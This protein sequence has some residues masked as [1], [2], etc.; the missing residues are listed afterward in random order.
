MMS[1][2][3]SLVVLVALCLCT[4]LASIIAVLIT[5]VPMDPWRN[6]T[7][8]AEGEYI[9][10]SDGIQLFVRS[11]LPGSEPGEV[12]LALHGLGQH[13]GYHARFGEA[14][15]RH[16][17]AYYALDLRGNGFTQ[18]AH[19]DIPSVIRLYSDL[20]ELCSLLHDRHPQ[21]PFYV[22]GHSMGAAMAACWAAEHNPKINGLLLLAPAMTAA[23]TPVPWSNYLK[24]PAAWLFFRHRSVLGIGKTAYARER[25]EKVVNLPDQVDF[26]VHDPLQLKGMSMEFALAANQFR[27]NAIPLASLVHVP[28]L[29]LVG[30]QDLSRV[31]AKQFHAGQKIA[32]K[33]FY[34]IPNAT[35]MLFQIQEMDGVVMRV[36]EWLLARHPQP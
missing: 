4:W 27:K 19:G 5:S 18:T 13:S 36:K 28:T 32:D 25:L 7:T 6:Q 26:I 34:L 14:L 10:A 21:S 30:D 2:L 24:G 22:L 3:Y 12:I 31:G 29:T 1:L 23:A 35:H 8:P 20:D 11:W 17:S 15:A 16:G 33:D 9:R